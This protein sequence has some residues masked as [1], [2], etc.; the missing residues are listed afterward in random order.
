MA[1]E[2]VVLQLRSPAVTS[3]E[4][5][6]A[7]W[8]ADRRRGVRVDK[9]DYLTGESVDV[10][11]LDLGCSIT[12]QIAIAEISARIKTMFGRFVRACAPL[13]GEAT[14]VSPAPIAE[15]RKLR[16]FM[17]LPR[18]QI[19]I[20]RWAAEEIDGAVAEGEA[21]CDLLRRFRDERGLVCFAIDREDA[22][23]GQPPDAAIGS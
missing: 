12:A 15:P 19:A 3:C 17:R 21:A 22:G 8:R 16:L 18:Y 20:H 2:A 23:T 9:Q 13:A 6:I 5:G 1:E 14:A 7:R 10:R 4:D 11:R